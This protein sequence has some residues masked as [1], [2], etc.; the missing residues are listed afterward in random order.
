LQASE[1]VAEEAMAPFLDGV[2]AT[3]QLLG[4]TQVGGLVGLAN[5]Q[6]EATAEGQALGRRAGA[7]Q[8]FQTL[9]FDV[10]EGHKR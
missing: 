3:A 1:A 8:G 2:A 4:H 6:D 7:G 10:T 9:A 5:A